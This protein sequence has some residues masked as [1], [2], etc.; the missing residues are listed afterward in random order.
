MILKAYGRLL[1]DFMFSV[2]ML[3]EGRR[4]GIPRVGSMWTR[5]RDAQVVATALTL[6]GNLSSANDV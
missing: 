2:I 3:W 4:E 6:L 1:H 5:S